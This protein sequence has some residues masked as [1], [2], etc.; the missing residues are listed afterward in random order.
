MIPGK[1]G[2][3]VLVRSIWFQGIEITVLT[4]ITHEEFSVPQEVKGHK[5]SFRYGVRSNDALMNWVPIPNRN[6]SVMVR[7]VAVEGYGMSAISPSKRTEMFGKV[8]QK[9]M[10]GCLTN[11]QKN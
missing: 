3:T 4:Y 9:Y 5:V 7:M 11:E 8:L 10:T 2:T 6:T 1:L